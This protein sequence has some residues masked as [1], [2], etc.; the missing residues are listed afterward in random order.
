MRLTPL[1]RRRQLA[2]G[3]IAVIGLP[4]LT[5]VLTQLRD[6]LGFTSAAFCYLILVVAV[7]TVGGVW[8]GRAGGGG[9]L[10]AAELVL[11]RAAST[12]S[13]SATSATSS[14]SSPSWSSRAS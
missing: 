14:P 3:L 1:S 5:L 4:L 11:R 13:P 12:R 7:A 6:E 8:P 10:R 2:G 9:R